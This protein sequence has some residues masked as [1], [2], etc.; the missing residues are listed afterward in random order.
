[1]SELKCLVELNKKEG[2]LIKLKNP[3]DKIDQTI[4]LDGT[5]ITLTCKGD[6][7]STIIEMSCNKVL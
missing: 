1:M 6:Q 3:D 4:I 7:D 2:I 5:K